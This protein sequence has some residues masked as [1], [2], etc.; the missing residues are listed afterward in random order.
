MC[1]LLHILLLMLV[2]KAVHKST[3]PSFHGPYILV[4]GSHEKQICTVICHMGK[5]TNN[6][7][8]QGKRFR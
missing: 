6:E 4:G 7:I 5:K 8:I 3:T 2:G 1:A